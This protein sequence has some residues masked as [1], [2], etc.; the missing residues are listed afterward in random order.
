MVHSAPGQAVG[1]APP[2]PPIQTRPGSNIQLN[3]YSPKFYNVSQ[4]SNIYQRVVLIHGSAGPPNTPFDASITVYHHLSEFPPQTYPVSDGYF[5]ALV[6][7]SPGTNDLKFVF[8]PG[9][10][11][12]PPLTTDLTLTY[13]PLL[14]NAPLHLAILLAKDSEC[15]FDSPTYKK[16][17]E[18]NGLDTAIKKMRMAGYLWQAYTGEQMSRNGMG[19]RAFQLYEEWG[20]DT[21]SKNDSACRTTAKVHI[22][23][24]NK[25]MAEIRDPDVAQQNP[26]GKRRGDLFGI[27]VDAIRNHGGMFAETPNKDETHVA[28]LFMDTKWDNQMKL[29]RGHAA[30]GGGSGNVK[31]A[32][33]GSHAIYSW[34]TCFEEVGPCFTDA[35]KEELREVAN[36]AGDP[37]LNFQAANVGMGAFLHEVGHLLGCPHEPSGIMLQGYTI[38]HRSFVT[39]EV[40]IGRESL[41]ICLP[42]DECEWHRLDLLR[43]RCHPMFRLPPE[44][45]VPQMKP[46]MYPVENGAIAMSSTGIYLIEIHCDGGCRA[47]LEYPEGPQKEVFLFEDELRSLMPSKYRTMNKPI[48]LEILALGLQ[49]ISVEDFSN[50]VK[51]ARFEIGRRPVFNSILSNPNTSNG[52]Q[53]I[54]VLFR[55]VKHIRIYHGSAVDGMEF[56]FDSGSAMFGNRGGSPSEFKMET[57]ETIVGLH[58]RIGA[59]IDA[60]QIITNLKRSAV[61]GN[62]RGGSPADLIP[63]LG[64][65]MVGIHGTVEHWLT[66]VGIIYSGETLDA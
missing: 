21:L 24:S 52:G 57:S 6:H 56:F 10:L 20:P 63:P 29:I 4:N 43:F 11:G 25:T 16:N 2:T 36:D 9:S 34:P 49:Q 30:L 64:Y 26:N 19:R 45:I 50:V 18:G 27:A 53:N 12:G 58:V 15:K 44:P 7:L 35:T 31:L 17:Q 3:P 47:H 39:R 54:K 51:N 28:V 42:K 62:S 1:L 59:W 13:T 60:I 37:G 22:I 61:Y 8:L 40:R 55:R 41:R 33:F 66:R 14:Q 65:Y 23:R 46:A 5:K 38:F 32:I 48:N